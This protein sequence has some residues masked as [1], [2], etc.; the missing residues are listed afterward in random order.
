MRIHVPGTCAAKERRRHPDRLK[1]SHS[2]ASCG[3][4]GPG[5][6]SPLWQDNTR[7]ADDALRPHRYHGAQPHSAAAPGGG[8]VVR[9]TGCG[10]PR[11][12]QR[13]EGR[14]HAVLAGDSQWSTDHGCGRS[15]ALETS[16]WQRRSTH[17][18]LYGSSLSQR[19]RAPCLSARCLPTACGCCRCQPGSCRARS[20][21]PR[22][23]YGQEACRSLHWFQWSQGR[24]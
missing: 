3:L 8:A 18:G 21:R 6:P 23:R 11:P 16:A 12:P 15:A 13:G 14:R 20:V 10:P 17:H 22:L 7:A 4:D 2:I 9:R 5:E 19:T 1:S 24:S